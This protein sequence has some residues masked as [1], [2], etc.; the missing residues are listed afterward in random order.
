MR[1]TIVSG[2]WK[3]GDKLAPEHQLTSYSDVSHVVRETLQ[4]LRTEHLIPTC[5][6]L[7]AFVSP[8][9][10]ITNLSPTA[11]LLISEFMDLMELRRYLEFHAI[12]LSA[13]RVTDEDFAQI[14]QAFF[15]AI[16]G[17]SET[18]YQTVHEL[19]SSEK[20]IFPILA[21][22]SDR[23]Q[24]SQGF[25]AAFDEL[26]QKLDILVNNAGITKR[27]LPEDFPIEDWDA[28]LAVNLDAV[29][30]LSQLAGRE[31]LRNGYGKIINIA[32]LTSFVGGTTIPAYAASKGT[33]GQLTKALSNDWC[34]RGICVNAIA[35]GYIETDLNTDLMQNPERSRKIL[36]RIPAGRWGKPEDIGGAAVFLASPAS[37]Y[38]SGTILNVDGGYLGC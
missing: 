11:D 1:E 22:F 8:R 7:G 15:L 38:I 29:F 9:N 31:M 14:A 3:E 24:I 6:G 10:F 5:Q 4:C 2:T 16:I 25:Y 34:G 20:G 23:T 35:P 27:F 19:D 17:R 33:V 36:D 18:I 13:T 30:M 12:E 37:D 21:D 28:V 32:S 26:D